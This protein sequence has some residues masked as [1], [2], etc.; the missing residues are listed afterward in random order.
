VGKWVKRWGSGWTGGGVL[1]T[2]A[3]TFE[4]GDTTN[5]VAWKGQRQACRKKV[6]TEELRETERAT[7]QQS[8]KT[9]NNHTNTTE[10]L[11]FNKKKRPC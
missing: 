5:P 4:R 7:T 3:V 2:R 9:F 11:N 6:K 10:L 8:T 1:L